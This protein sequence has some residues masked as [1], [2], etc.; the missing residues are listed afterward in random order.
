LPTVITIVNYDYKTFK[1]QATGLTGKH[2]TRPAR[3]NTS[4]L[5][6]LVNYG[7]KRVLYDWDQVREEVGGVTMLINNAGI[8]SGTP[9]LDTPDG[10]TNSGATTGGQMILS[11]KAPSRMT[12]RRKA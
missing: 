8:V 6:T 7:R 3:E 12:F 5:H 4:L 2:Y 1:V 11:R 9:L 10:K